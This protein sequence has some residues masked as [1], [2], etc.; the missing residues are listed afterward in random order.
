VT[1][2]DVAEL[3]AYNLAAKQARCEHVG[4]S[5][6]CSKCGKPLTTAERLW[7]W[8]DKFVESR[9]KAGDLDWHGLGFKADE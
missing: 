5:W 3:E 9:K 6:A 2:P 4:D 7:L 1:N 8:A